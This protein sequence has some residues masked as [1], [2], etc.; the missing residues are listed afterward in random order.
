MI[1]HDPACGHALHGAACGLE[2]TGRT[3]CGSCAKIIAERS[4]GRD[5][6]LAQLEATGDMKVVLAAQSAAA[7]CTYTLPTPLELM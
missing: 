2:L 5:D 4:R 1:L 6:M 7:A 3:T